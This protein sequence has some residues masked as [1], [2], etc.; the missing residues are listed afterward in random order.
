MDTAK[1]KAL[2]KETVV[3]PMMSFIEEY[4]ADGYSKE[5]VQKC[6][7]LIHQYLDNLNAISSPKNEDIM[8]QVK[9][10]IIALNKLNEE[11][12]YS[13]IETQEREAIS[14]IIQTSAVDCGL[15]DPPDD[16]TEEWREW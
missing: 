14:E 1:Y 13:L 8:E 4:G 10:L 16:V 12:D 5:D 2:T 3:D 9:M 15:Q 7:G 11:T 6:E